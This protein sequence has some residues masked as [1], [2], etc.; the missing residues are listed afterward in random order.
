LE[1]IKGDE[2]IDAFKRLQ[3]M[4]GEKLAQ[5]RMPELAL[6]H[7]KI[8]KEC[9]DLGPSEILFE[10]AKDIGERI[11]SVQLTRD[12]REFEE[13]SAL[14]DTSIEELKKPISVRGHWW[15]TGP[16]YSEVDGF[17]VSGV[18]VLLHHIKK[19]ALEAPFIDQDGRRITVSLSKRKLR[20]R[21]NIEVFG[22]AHRPFWIEWVR[23]EPDGDVGLRWSHA[24]AWD[25]RYL[26]TELRNFAFAHAHVV[27]DFDNK[28]TPCNSRQ[29]F[30]RI[31]IEDRIEKAGWQESSCIPIRGYLDEQPDEWFQHR[32]QQGDLEHFMLNWLEVGLKESVRPCFQ[33]YVT[34]LWAVHTGEHSLEI[35]LNHLVPSPMRIAMPYPARRY[36]IELMAIDANG[37]STQ[38]P[39]R[40]GDIERLGKEIKGWIGELSPNVLGSDGAPET[41]LPEHSK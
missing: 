4:L 24:S 10:L 6:K 20:Y 1:A 39:W 16:P 3:A 36:R 31:T 21:L 18:Q 37:E 15:V 27:R 14:I 26:R 35:V 28:Q 11:E 40:S 17:V 41:G 9:P 34:K 25:D 33:A 29:Q 7:D 23:C 32:D 22:F 5:D 38:S 2:P 12:V 30:L 19:L 8:R 13:L